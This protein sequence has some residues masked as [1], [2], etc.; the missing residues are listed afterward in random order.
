MKT[1]NIIFDFGG[2]LVDWNPRYL[3]KDYFKEDSEMEYFLKNICTEE[4]NLEQDRGRALAEG[5]TLLQNKFPEYKS[6]IQLFYD[7]WEVM[8]K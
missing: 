5:T 7:K 8:L 2:V 3:Y 1:E 4:W 6:L